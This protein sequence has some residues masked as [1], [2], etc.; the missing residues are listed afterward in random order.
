MTAECKDR[1]GGYSVYIV[2][3]KPNGVWDSVEVNVSN[4]VHVVG[5]NEQHAEIPNFQPA[6]KYEVSVATQS[7]TRKSDPYVF[8][9][10][11]DARGELP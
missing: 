2:W 5:P 11:T 10:A 8:T 4:K 1:A 6:R 7:G 9:C 3:G